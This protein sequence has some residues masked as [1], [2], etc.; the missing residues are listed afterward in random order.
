MYQDYIVELDTPTDDLTLAKGDDVTVIGMGTLSS[1]GS[2]PSAMQEV[3]VDYITNADCCAKYSYSCNEITDRMLCAARP[4]QDSCQGDSGG[5]LF[6]DLGNGK[7]KQ[8]GVVS[9][10]Y[11][12]ADSNYP[13]G[14]N[15]Q[16]N[17]SNRTWLTL[18][19]ILSCLWRRCHI[20]SV[21]PCQRG[22][23]LDQDTNRQ[24]QLLRNQSSAREG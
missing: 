11:G 14:K 17:I 15:S 24:L 9:W 6:V 7:Y 20:R 12:C 18:S 22:I 16:L 8:V 2:T 3:T 1:G 5:P 4:G 23:H 13:G 19:R 21:L 10:G